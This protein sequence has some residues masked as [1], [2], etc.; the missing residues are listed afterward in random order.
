MVHQL[1]LTELSHLTSC[2]PLILSILVLLAKFVIDEMFCFSLLSP[3]PDYTGAPSSGDAEA[4]GFTMDAPS[5][6][7]GT[8]APAQSDS[9]RD[10]DL[11]SRIQPDLDELMCG[12]VS[13]TRTTALKPLSADDHGME[14]LVGRLSSK[15]WLGCEKI[16]LGG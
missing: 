16:W 15:L 2:F 13:P 14:I 10:L 3:I 12:A 8:V 7:D 11:A 5:S 9:D 4:Y 6:G 1:D